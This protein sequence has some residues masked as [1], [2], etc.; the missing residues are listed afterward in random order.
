MQRLHV[1]SHI[2]RTAAESLVHFFRNDA[3]KRLTRTGIDC[4]HITERGIAPPHFF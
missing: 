3:G 4:V 2:V 1:G